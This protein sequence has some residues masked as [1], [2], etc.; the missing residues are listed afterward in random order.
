MSF[1]TES[2]THKQVFLEKI[3]REMLPSSFWMKF[4]GISELIANGAQD[5]ISPVTDKS[6]T[7]ASPAGSP[8]V[9]FRDLDAEKRGAKVQFPLTK[10]L[11]G[12]GLKGSDTVTLENNLERLATSQFEMELEE[13]LHGVEA[14]NPL[15]RQRVY[16]SITE[17][18]AQSLAA[19]GIEKIDQL[20]FDALQKVPA[21]NITY[22]G[23]A[24]SISTLTAND[25]LT[26]DLLRQV[27]VQAKSSFKGK[28]PSRVHQ[29]YKIK[30][31]KY[32]GK[33]YYFVVVHPDVMHDL[34]KDAEFKE[35][36]KYVSERGRDN[37]LFTGA[38]AITMDG[39]VIFSHDRSYITDPNGSGEPDWGE[40]ADVPGAKVT[41]F[42]ENALAVALGKAPSISTQYKDFGRRIEYGYQGIYQVKKIAFDNQDYGFSEIRCARSRI[43]DAYRN[44]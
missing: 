26:I 21:S 9:V 16:F 2:S 28:G 27:K 30:P 29:K 33:D 14:D 18:C 34:Q 44:P 35:A 20:C 13:Y 3:F 17:S 40:G 42:G 23:T 32:A 38:D 22:A 4:S 6:A 43:S 11:I 37:L 1:M 41:L 31:Y 7:W 25:K 15:G 24:T 5:H 10:A 8:I 36:M 12:D 39:L 19:W